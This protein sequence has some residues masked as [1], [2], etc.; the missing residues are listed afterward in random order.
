[1]TITQKQLIEIARKHPVV[2]SIQLCQLQDSLIDNVEGEYYGGYGPDTEGVYLTFTTGSSMF[3]DL[4][5]P[6]F[7]IQSK[8][9]HQKSI[10]HI[11]AEDLNNFFSDLSVALFG[12]ETTEKLKEQAR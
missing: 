12:A 4:S 8:T 1:M 3:L 7:N 11:S 10:E 9:N 2:R 6:G 5:R